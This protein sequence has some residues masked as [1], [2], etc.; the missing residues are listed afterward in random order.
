MLVEDTPYAQFS[1]CSLKL[2]VD[3]YELVTMEV[4]LARPMDVG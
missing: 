2:I 4:V 1:H 3:V